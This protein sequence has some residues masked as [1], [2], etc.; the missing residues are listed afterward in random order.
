MFLWTPGPAQLANGFPIPSD[1]AAEAVAAICLSNGA[2]RRPLAGIVVLGR[3]LGTKPGDL[4]VAVDGVDPAE[5]GFTV[6]MDGGIVIEVA[7]P[8][9]ALLA[10]GPYGALFVIPAA[11]DVLVARD[12]Q[13]AEWLP[14]VREGRAHDQRGEP[15][16][17]PR[18][19]APGDGWRPTRGAPVPALMLSV[20]N[21]GPLPAQPG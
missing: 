10:P 3:W 8:G 15:C 4:A 5:S 14:S 1:R 7:H 9:D 13:P 20:W 19:K 16:R 2:R 21:P 11:H 17:W 6:R 18:R 12:G